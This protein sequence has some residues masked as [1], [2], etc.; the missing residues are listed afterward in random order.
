MIGAF[1]Y[2]R[3]IKKSKHFAD[4]ISQLDKENFIED[5]K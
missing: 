4:R 2:P 3:D 1:R 5:T